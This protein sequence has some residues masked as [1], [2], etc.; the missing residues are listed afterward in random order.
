MSRN[1]AEVANWPYVIRRVK[2]LRMVGMPVLT[3]GLGPLVRISATNQSNSTEEHLE[4][5][6]ELSAQLP[7]FHLFHQSCDPAFEDWYPLYLD[8]FRQTTRY[9]FRINDLRDLERVFAGFKKGIRSDI[10]RAEKKLT[11]RTD[12]TVDRILDMVDHTYARQGRVAPVPRDVVRRL[13][14]ACDTHDACTRL[15]AE[16][17]GGRP[18]AGALVVWGGGVGYWLLSGADPALRS[19]AAGP[20]LVWRAIQA[21]AAEHTVFDFEGSMVAPIAEYFNRFGGIRT[22]YHDLRAERGAGRLAAA[23]ADAAAR[24]R[25]RP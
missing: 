2:G 4:L 3:R 14:A 11:V 16:D 5:V 22:P 21:T 19:S 20:L 7:S 15:L 24:M 23:V 17:A 9:T 10:R 25:G 1:G 8:G 6:R 12:V 13:A 18:H